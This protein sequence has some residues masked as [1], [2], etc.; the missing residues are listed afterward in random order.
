MIKRYTYNVYKDGEL[1]IS[2][3]NNKEVRV[4]T[5]LN[6]SQVATYA[7]SGRKYKGFEIE[8]MSTIEITPKPKIVKS[9]IN[10]DKQFNLPEELKRDWDNM[11]KA[12]EI[13]KSG[14]GKIV[15]HN[16]KRFVEVIE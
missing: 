3:V 10:E 9:I 13:I 11:C 6:N 1:I 5:G 15:C 14:K 8:I 2:G 12:A 7:N 16:G 4:M